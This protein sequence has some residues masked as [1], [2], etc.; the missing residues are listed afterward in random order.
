[1]KKIFIQLLL[2]SIFIFL[3]ACNSTTPQKH[4]SNTPKSEQTIDMKNCICVQLWMPVCGENGITYSN[5]C[6]AKCAN[7]KYEQGAC[8]KTI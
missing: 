3:A 1:M 5:A 7:V 2:T 6:F 4:L 8:D